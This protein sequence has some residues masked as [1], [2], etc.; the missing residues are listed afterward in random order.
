MVT[1][2]HLSDVQCLD[3]FSY[4]DSLKKYLEKIKNRF[5]I[6]PQTVANLLV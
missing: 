1:R 3:E 6:A 5:L 2:S 4:F